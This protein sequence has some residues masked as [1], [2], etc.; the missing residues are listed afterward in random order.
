L[1]P[2]FQEI[3]KSL[4]LIMVD[5]AV[6]DAVGKEFWKSQLP[7]KERVSWDRFREAICKNTSGGGV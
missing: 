7:G 5:V 3:I 6:H 1:R 4:E 2:S